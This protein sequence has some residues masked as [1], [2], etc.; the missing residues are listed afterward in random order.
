VSCTV[1]AVVTGDGCH[2]WFC[3]ADCNHLHMSLFFNARQ[4]VL[5]N[6]APRVTCSA[7]LVALSNEAFDLFLITKTQSD[8]KMWF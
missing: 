3:D 2:T 8:K 5:E 7:P 4:D 6:Q 1:G